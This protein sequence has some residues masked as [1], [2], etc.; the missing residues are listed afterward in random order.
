MRAPPRQVPTYVPVM[1]LNNDGQYREPGPSAKTGKS[2]LER[3]DG[4]VSLVQSRML[5]RD[6]SDVP[7]GLVEIVHDGEYIAG[8]C[9]RPIEY[10]RFMEIA[11]SGD[12]TARRIRAATRDVSY[13]PKLD[14]CLFQRSVQIFHDEYRLGGFGDGFAKLPM[15]ACLRL[16]QL[17]I[18]P[19]EADSEHAD[20]LLHEDARVGAGLMRDGR[21]ARGKEAIACKL[22]HAERCL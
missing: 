21:Q 19:E 18:S 10:C 7:A 20:A 17:E 14:R 2:N 12:I 13:D 8:R 5:D 22:S 15:L 1:Q 11:C 6:H 9:R 4:R 3:K 16:V